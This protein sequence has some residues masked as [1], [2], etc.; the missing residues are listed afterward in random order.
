[1]GFFFNFLWRGLVFT[2]CFLHISIPLV[3]LPWECQVVKMQRQTA[4]LLQL[5]PELTCPE[6]TCLLSPPLTGRRKS[7]LCLGFPE[8]T[9]TSLLNAIK[10]ATQIP[11]CVCHP[12]CLF[13]SA[14][15]WQQTEKILKRVR[16]NTKSR[17]L[18]HCCYSWEKTFF[19]CP[20]HTRASSCPERAAK[21]NLCL[22]ETPNIWAVWRG[23]GGGGGKGNFT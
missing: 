18:W 9:E 11:S 8:E 21:P 6:G 5:P 1:M 23:F 14:L 17:T 10:T 2:Y 12:G 4:Q 16:M 22:A 13:F 7:T 20:L 3:L 19:L 15:L